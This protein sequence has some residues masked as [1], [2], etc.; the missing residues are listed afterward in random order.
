MSA[1]KQPDPVA[2]AV[3]NLSRRIQRLNDLVLDAFKEDPA[4]MIAVAKTLGPKE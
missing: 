1:D 2:V 3:A 4:L